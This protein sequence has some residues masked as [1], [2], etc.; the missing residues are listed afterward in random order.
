VARRLYRKQVVDGI[1]QLDEGALLDDF[2]Y[3]LHE[4]GVVDLLS[5][6]QG[7]AAQREMVPCVQYVLRYSLKTV[8]GIASMNALPALLR[9]DAALM[10]LVG[11]NAQ[12]V[13]HGVG[14]RGA[15]QRQGPP[16]TGPICADALA[17][18]IV[19]LNLQGLEAWFNRVIRALAQAAMFAAKV[20]GIVEAPDLETTEHDEGWGQVTRKRTITDKRGK[21][22]AIE[23]TVYGL[24]LIA[25]IDART[26]IPLAAKVVPIQ[27][28]E[29]L[30]LRALVTQARTNLAGYAR[31]HKVLFDKGF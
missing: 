25:L 11:F 13:R 28:H 26:K 15:A 30:S 6:V 19:Q 31:L 20:T 5:D 22:H 12:Q 1:S 7:T 23:V 8:F 21:I 14:Q 24:K 27:E 9:S 4:L 29:T 10:R 2:F 18:T 16:T 17:D 3:F